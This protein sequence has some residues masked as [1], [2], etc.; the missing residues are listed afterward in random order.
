MT[1]ATATIPVPIAAR[2]RRTGWLGVVPILAGRRLAL[3]VRSPRSLLVPLMAPLLFA[4]VVAPGLANSTAPPGQ[5]TIA[6]TYFALATAGLLI[7]LNAM[8]SGLGVVLDRQHGAMPE[9]LVAPI[10][11]SSIVMGNLL[12][13][14]AITAFQVTVLL[15]VAAVRG[16]AFELGSRLGWFVLAAFLLTVTMYSVAEILAAFL[17][18]PE[19]YTGALPAVAIVPFFFAGSLFPIS[20]LPGWLAVIGKALPLTHAL[21]LFRYGLTEPGTKALHDIWGSSSAPVMAALSAGVLVGYSILFLTVAVRV[22]SRAG[23][24]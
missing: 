1:T 19:E 11:R 14:L 6:M 20:S 3:T 5:R 10:R 9:L 7:P 22:F 15:G 4:L 18:S 16:A 13:A 21:A 12:A 17:H 8:F 23:T 2:P 24:T